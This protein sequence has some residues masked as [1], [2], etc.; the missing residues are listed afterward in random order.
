MVAVTQGHFDEEEREKSTENWR[1]SKFVHAP[2]V[3]SAPREQSWR[4]RYVSTLARSVA[5]RRHPFRAPERP[6][7]PLVMDIPSRSSDDTSYMIIKEV[8]IVHIFS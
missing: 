3:V 6:P 2:V 5:L 1:R 8:D 4:A 7:L